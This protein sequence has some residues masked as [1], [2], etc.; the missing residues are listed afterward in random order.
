MQTAAIF[1]SAKPTTSGYRDVS[2]EGLRSALGTV[3]VVDV[4]EPHELTGELGHIAG[5]ELAPLSTVAARAASWPRD[6]VIVLVCRSGARSGSAA[7]T[8]V[9]AGFHQ[10]LNLAGGMLAYNAAGFPVVKR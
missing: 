3:R 6:Q 10:V 5:V 7:R 1:T 9:D 2:P 8:L 4:R